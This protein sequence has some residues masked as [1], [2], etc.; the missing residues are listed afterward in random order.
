MIRTGNMKAVTERRGWVRKVLMTRPYKL[1]LWTAPLV[2]LSS[3]AGNVPAPQPPALAAPLALAPPA[4]SAADIR[5]AQQHA[6]WSGYAAGQNYQKR[7]DAQNRPNDPSPAAGA[8]IVGTASAPA[9]PTAPGVV[10]APDA[11]AS[12]VTPATAATP[13]VSPPAQPVPSPQDSYS[14]KGPA[15]PVA[16]PVN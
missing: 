9:V 4:V 6:Y 12:A 11:S 3:C 8:P 2:L 10:P 14:A 13:P 16:T 15:R 1:P 5:K 7:Q